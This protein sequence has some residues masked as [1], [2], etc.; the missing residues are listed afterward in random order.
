MERKL[1]SQAAKSFNIHLHA[2]NLRKEDKEYL[3]NLS[4]QVCTKLALYVNPLK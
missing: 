2:R 3:D 1:V 4:N